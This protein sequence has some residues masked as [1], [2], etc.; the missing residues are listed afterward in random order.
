LESGAERRVE[1]VTGIF[2][3]LNDGKEEE[4]GSGW[5]RGWVLGGRRGRGRKEGMKEW[6]KEG[7][8]RK[9]GRRGKGQ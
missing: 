2:G 3:G 4:V 8:N 5:K 6:R 7:T 9:G 1:R